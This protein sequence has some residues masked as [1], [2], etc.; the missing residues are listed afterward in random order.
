MNIFAM[1]ICALCAVIFG[2]LIKKSNIEY[3]VVISVAAS[4]TALLVILDSVA[5]AIEQISGFAE[6][7]GFPSYVLPIVLRSAGIAITGQ[8]VS[9]VCK[10]S[11]ES[12]LGF[13]VELAAKAAILAVSL[14]LITAVFE[15]LEE[16]V[17]L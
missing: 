2:A 14:P 9:G 6:S 13:T 7:T 1:C 17:K 16:L 8:L 3:A 4:V 11:G 15:Y 10:D 12:A 5:P